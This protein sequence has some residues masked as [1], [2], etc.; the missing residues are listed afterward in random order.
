MLAHANKTIQKARLCNWLVRIKRSKS[1]THNWLLWI[2]R[3][4]RVFEP[5]SQ[6]LPVRVPY[7]NNRSGHG[8]LYNSSRSGLG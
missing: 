4:K 3:S 2:K 7:R 8:C 1:K 5:V 6:P